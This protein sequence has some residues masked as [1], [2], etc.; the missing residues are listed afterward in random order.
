NALKPLG[1]APEAL[2]Q[3]LEGLAHDPV[4][5]ADGPTLP[6][7]AILSH[8]ETSIRRAL[9]LALGEYDVQR[10][11]PGETRDELVAMLLD[12][13]RNDVDAGIHGA[14]EWTLRQWKQ[15]KTLETAELPG[16]EHRGDRRWFVNSAG[17]TLSLI[18][19]PVE[20]TMG[21]PATEPDRFTQE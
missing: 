13:Y 15:E 9:V 10:D 21:S 8:P 16:F 3:K 11:L 5:Q 14:A 12:A 20:F 4:P 7:D 18:A 17:Q 19:G 1:T 6:I 2:K